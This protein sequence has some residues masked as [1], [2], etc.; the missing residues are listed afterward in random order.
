MD[1]PPRGW[2]VICR[3]GS[4]RYCVHSQ[5]TSEL[6]R[7]KKLKIVPVP[8]AHPFLAG[9]LN[10][11]GVILPVVDL[12]RVLGMPT[13]SEEID[14]MRQFVAGRE[15]DHVGWLQELRRC[16]ES[17]ATFTKALDPTKCAFGQWYEKIR[18]NDAAR[19]SL[20][21]GTVVLEKILDDFDAPHRRIHGIAESVLQ[22]AQNG[23]LDE[24]RAKIE[25]AWDTDLATM[26]R[27]FARFFQAFQD[28]R[29]PSVVSMSVEGVPFAV[30][31]DEVQSVRE[32]TEERFEPAPEVSLADHGLVKW[33][34]RF[35]DDLVMLLDV[36]ALV[37]TIQPELAA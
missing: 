31:V 2:Y 13:F 12:R 16:A 26:K 21:G 8:G 34:T 27:L 35:E 18:S 22:L 24:A 9:I 15:Q 5:W 19:A 10:Q 17:G 29:V 7:T 30:I 20:S 3:L 23:G 33:V 4:E 14:D 37:K 36:P 25:E 6:V 1:C 32:C 28:L 11:R